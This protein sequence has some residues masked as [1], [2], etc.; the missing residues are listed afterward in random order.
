M[1]EILTDSG[2]VPSLARSVLIGGVGF[3][4]VSLCVFLTVVFGEGWMHQ[5]LGLLGSYLTWTAIFIVGG[6]G[7]LGSLVAGR[8]PLA[9]FYLLFALAFLGYAAGWMVSY[10]AIGGTTGEAIG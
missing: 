8:R 2:K 5:H 3:S 4:L 6:G 7:V 1:S 9:R 10:F